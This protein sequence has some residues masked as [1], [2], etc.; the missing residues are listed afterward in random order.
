MEILGGNSLKSVL[1]C[2]RL[3]AARVSE[4]EPTLSGGTLARGTPSARAPASNAAFKVP[5]DDG[6]RYDMLPRGML[7][8]WG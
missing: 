6:A 5:P 1:R 2:S 4:P 3:L 8:Q 7:S